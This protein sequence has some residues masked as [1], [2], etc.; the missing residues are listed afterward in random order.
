MNKKILF[1]VFFIGIFLGTVDILFAEEI[2]LGEG[3]VLNEGK[4]FLN[5]SADFNPI[6]VK[7]LVNLFPEISTI[8]CTENGEEK[9]Y[10]NVFG[11]IGENFVMLPNRTYEVVSKREV[12]LD[13][14]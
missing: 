11:G 5:T 4:T 7:D 9:G 6:Y 13:L 1:A 12:I 3:I 14:I 10:V 8:S 2:D